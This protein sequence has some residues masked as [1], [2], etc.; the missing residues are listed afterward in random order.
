MGEEG[1]GILHHLY[2]V[3]VPAEPPVSIR[4]SDGHHV[5]R[6]E[7]QDNGATVLVAKLYHRPERVDDAGNGAY[8]SERFCGV[9]GAVWEKEP[10]FVARPR[11]PRGIAEVA[12][13]G[14]Q[15]VSVPRRAEQMRGSHRGCERR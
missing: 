1:R 14:G 6:I 7:G 8:G 11:G 10:Q 3:R 9:K 4:K 15:T 12:L 13:I 5:S 2:Q